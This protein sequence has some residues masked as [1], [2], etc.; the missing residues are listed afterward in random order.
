MKNSEGYTG[1]QLASIAANHVCTSRYF[2][3]VKAAN[4]LPNV[5]NDYPTFFIVNSDLTWQKG[6]HWLLIILTAPNSSLIYFDALG[7]R[8]AQYS[9]HIDS[10]LHR[11]S[12]TFYLGNT[13]RYQPANSSLCG[14]YCLYVADRICRGQ[15]FAKVLQSLNSQNLDSNDQTVTDYY[16]NHLLAEVHIK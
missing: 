4:N 5:I 3:G 12:K 13:L 6:S 16:K 2:G 1:R 7:K 9:T 14:L 8:A 11:H 15:T 10:F